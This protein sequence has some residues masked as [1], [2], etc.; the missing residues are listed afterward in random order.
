VQ[1]GW[2][3][4]WSAFSIAYMIGCPV[5]STTPMWTGSML[6]V[7]GIVRERT[8]RRLHDVGIGI[9]FSVFTCSHKH[10]S[11]NSQTASR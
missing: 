6:S 1:I 8:M 2:P 5:M 7:P 3:F 9:M 4:C 11:A 10:D